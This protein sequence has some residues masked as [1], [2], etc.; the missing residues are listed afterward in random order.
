MTL[1]FI[2]SIGYRCYSP[3]F[4][5]RHNLRKISSPF[6]YL[7]V[8]IETAF[9]AIHTQFDEYLHD[10]V[11]FHKNNKQAELYYPK[12]TTSVNPQWNTLFDH[13]VK[14]MGNSYDDTT[15][16]FNQ[17]YVD[18]VSS[19]LYDWNRI[20]LFLHHNLL[21]STVYTTLRERCTRMTSIIN[22]YPDTTALLYMTKI[23]ESNEDDY[24]DYILQLKTKYN[25]HCTIIVI[26]NCSNRKE[27]TIVREGCLFIIH[28]VASYYVQ[29]HGTDNN[30]SYT[31]PFQ[32]ISHHF[33]LQLIEQKD[34]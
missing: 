20:C 15:L 24:M 22:T 12:K 2:F 30:G 10:I 16:L 8:D 17:N 34:L 25:I 7:M 23:I 3:E 28:P 21:D 14:Y 31:T 13:S 18:S 26:M 19:N 27:E 6:D 32:I 5:K 33:K 11:L 4:L 9:H 29:Q 1:Q